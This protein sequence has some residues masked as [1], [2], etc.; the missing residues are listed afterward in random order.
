MPFAPPQLLHPI[1][2]LGQ[3]WLINPT[4][5][6]IVVVL[7]LLAAGL[8]ASVLVAA[9]QLATL[10]IVSPLS[11]EFTLGTLALALILSFGIYWLS[12]WLQVQLWLAYE[13]K[14]IRELIHLLSQYSRRLSATDS[15]IKQTIDS[16]MQKVALGARTS[17][18]RMGYGVRSSFTIVNLSIRLVIFLIALLAVSGVIAWTMILV[19]A[20]I[21]MPLLYVQTKI[22][23]RGER[24]R[25]L[26]RRDSSRVFTNVLPS[27]LNQI[28]P[29][30]VEAYVEGESLALKRQSVFFKTHARLKAITSSVLFLS[31]AAGLGV[32]ASLGRP[33]S[34]TQLLS[35]LLLGIPIAAAMQGIVG[36]TAT[37]GRFYPNY[38][39]VN[40]LF[41]LMKAETPQLELPVFLGGATDGIILSESD[42]SDLT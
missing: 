5:S 9:G 34:V 8:Q 31:A 6:L 32:A 26:A 28:E 35:L 16:H 38:Q 2:Y 30:V 27:I 22:I 1:R 10:S 7:G 42:G 41:K 23:A 17:I 37:L 4:R 29:E 12:E 36:T 11:T 25:A 40:D 13:R 21:A 24:E 18:I 20:L 3:V 33:P 14:F 15:S 39:Y 19:I